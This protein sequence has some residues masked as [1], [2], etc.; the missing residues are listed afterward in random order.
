MWQAI[1]ERIGFVEH[2][3]AGEE[4]EL[5]RVFQYIDT[6]GSGYINLDELQT[7]IR[8]IDT[9]INDVQI[10]KILKAA[11]RSGDDLISY[12]EFQAVFKSLKS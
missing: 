5:Y 3:I 1:A 9:Y 10:E 6:D 11:D 8:S 7:Y 2:I 12:E 4:K